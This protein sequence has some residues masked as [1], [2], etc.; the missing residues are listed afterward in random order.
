MA[1]DPALQLLELRAGVHAELLDEQ[2]A[3]GPASGERVG[4]PPRAVER[5]RVLRAHVLPVGLGRDQPLQFLRRGVRDFARWL[6]VLFHD[7]RQ[8]GG[9]RFT[10]EC[11]LAC[12]HLVQHRAEGK[13]VGTRIQSFSLRLLRRHVCDRAQRR[14]WTSKV[15]RAGFHRG[16]G[17]THLCRHRSAR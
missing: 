13:K 6:R 15:F 10:P 14:A 4:L 17:G 9:A 8:C 3:G 1:Q 2:L 5:Q 7:G 16:L 11:A 12:D